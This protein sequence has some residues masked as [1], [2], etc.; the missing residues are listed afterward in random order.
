MTPRSKLRNCLGNELTFCSETCLDAYR[1][2]VYLKKFDVV[3]NGL[4][5][6][7]YL[8]PEYKEY[9]ELIPLI[10]QKKENGRPVI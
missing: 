3:E 10:E 1:D 7:N 8:P 6:R 5:I 9:K 2:Q 4:R